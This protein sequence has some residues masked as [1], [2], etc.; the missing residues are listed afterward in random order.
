MKC[1]HTILKP[2]YYTET[3][4]LGHGYYSL[5]LKPSKIQ[6]LQQVHSS[7]ERPDFF[8]PTV[9]IGDLP[10]PFSD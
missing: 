5:S 2:F 3:F 8:F 1:I 6:K 9:K 4:I 10:F 7:I